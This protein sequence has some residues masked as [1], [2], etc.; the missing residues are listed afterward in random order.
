MKGLI[1]LAIC[2]VAVNAWAQTSDVHYR[3]GMRELEKGE[4][5]TAAAEFKRA[6]VLDAKFA[7]AYVGLALV[8]METGNYGGALESLKQAR[9]YDKK[10]VDVYLAQSRVYTRARQKE[11]EKKA[12][13]ELERAEKIDSKDDRIAYYR[14]VVYRQAGK[15]QAAAQSFGASVALKGSMAP[16]AEYAQKQMQLIL[17]ASQEV[18]RVGRDVA[19]KAVATRADLALLLADEF[20]LRG[21]LGRFRP[22]VVDTQ[23]KVSDL[24]AMPVS[25]RSGMPDD[26]TSHPNR[27]TILDV[28]AM[29][30]PGLELYPDGRFGPM[31]PITRAEFA[32]I[33]Q[34]LMAVRMNDHR[35]ATTY[36]GE[37]S[38]VE[39][40]RAD[41]FAYNAAVVCIQRGVVLPRSDGR[42]G[43]DEPLS[44][45][46]VVLGVVKTLGF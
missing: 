21:W 33:M 7:P 40:L 23:F 3:Q 42:F 9:K 41:H 28:L 36:F 2:L 1:T 34:G 20:D 18:H 31:Q 32:R 38:R 24:D 17:R 10:L 30:V 4:I 27:N 45:A 11:W 44:G 16:Q 14:G 35:L 39:D 6:Q 22:K 19:L 15:F 37:V 5:E 8:A 12:I 26:L 13:K 43:P 46:E 29:D 25:G